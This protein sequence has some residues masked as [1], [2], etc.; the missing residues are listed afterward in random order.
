MLYQ[1]PIE[2]SGLTVSH[3]QPKTTTSDKY[4][5]HCDYC[6][7]SRHTKETCWQLH[8]RPTRGRGGKQVS[9]SGAQANVAESVDTSKETSSR[10][11]LSS[12]EIQ[13]LHHL[14]T[15]LDSSTIASSNY[16]QSGT[17]FIA[18]LDS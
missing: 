9:S 14:L 15:K 18:H 7:K 1:A 17:A 12:D 13:H 6:G 2:K 4:H 3:V 10:E 16:V 8:G 11:T 5:L